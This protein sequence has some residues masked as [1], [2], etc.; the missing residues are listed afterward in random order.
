MVVSSLFPGR[1]RT[2]RAAQIVSVDLAKGIIELEVGESFEPLSGSV[3]LSVL[4]GGEPGVL[5]SADV[6][7]DFDYVV[8]NVGTVEPSR[9]FAGQTIQLSGSNLLCGGEEVVRVE[10]LPENVLLEFVSASNAAM[11]LFIPDFSIAETTE[12][13]LM[14]PSRPAATTSLRRW[15]P[16]WFLSV[17]KHSII[18]NRKPSRYPAS[19]S[20]PESS[21]KSS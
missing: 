17:S 6:D 21:P 3:E 16:G 4:F 19:T 10:L 14:L 2:R 13:F 12:V 11:T 20:H 7:L 8:P 1:R 15:P 18:R 5:S 9:F